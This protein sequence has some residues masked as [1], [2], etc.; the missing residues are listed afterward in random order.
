MRLRALGYCL[1]SLALACSGEGETGA[2]G[3]SG[4][5]VGTGGGPLGGGGVAA[6]GGMTS[7]GGMIAEPTGGHGEEPPA[8]GGASGGSTA[9]GGT[10]GASGGSTAPGGTGGASGGMTASGGTGGTTATGGTGG[11]SGGM[12]ASGGTGGGSGGSTASGGTGGGGTP[13]GGSAGSAAGGSGTATGGSGGGDGCPFS[14]HVEYRLNQ[15]E[16]WPA[17]ARELIVAAMDE[18][19]Y[20]YNCYAD[21]TQ[22]ITVNYNPGVPTAEAN[23]DGWL[24]FG[25]DEGYMV[26]PTAMHEISHTLGVGYYPWAELIVDSRWVGPA[27]VEYITN[28]PAEQ[29]D[30]DTY[31]QRDY[32]TADNQHFWPYGLNRASEY[33]S[34]WSLINNVRLVAAINEDKRA[35][36]NGEL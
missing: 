21:L 8:T 3:G 28:L 23:I 32:I 11:A 16:T 14:G 2:V 31:S 10:G 7:T 26:T 33:Q 9:S 35:Y 30:P 20:Y 13:A 15:P 27:V 29:R 1:A 22:S 19:V 18:G 12:T 17:H 25:A 34:E 5:E 4:G 6:L 36:L 24:S